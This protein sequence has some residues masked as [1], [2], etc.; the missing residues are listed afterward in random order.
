PIGVLVDGA[1]AVMLVVVTLVSTLVQTYSLAYMHGDP[2]FKRYY[3]FLSFFT[4]SMLGLVLSN[5]LFVTFACWEL[6]GVSSYLLIGFWF[7]KPG[8]AYASKKAFI[9][10]KLGDCGLYI[11]LLLIFAKMGTFQITQMRQ[12]VDM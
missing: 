12:F 10:T 9:T 2:R 11:A 1:A 3:A 6:V 7:E 4:A 5:N 8:P